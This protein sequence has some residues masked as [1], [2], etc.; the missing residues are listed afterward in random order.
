MSDDSSDFGSG[1]EDSSE[2]VLFPEDRENLEKAMNDCV[3]I[4]SA[5]A[6]ADPERAFEAIEVFEEVHLSLSDVQISDRIGEVVELLHEVSDERV[7][8]FEDARRGK[9]MIRNLAD[10]LGIRLSHSDS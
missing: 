1:A 8:N 2:N 4:F 9:Y 10:V 3:E 7:L 5:P 6:Q